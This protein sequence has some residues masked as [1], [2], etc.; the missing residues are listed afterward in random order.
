MTKAPHEF[1]RMVVR[2]PQSSGDFAAVGATAQ[3]A[4]LLGLHLMAAFIEDI[5][6][7]EVAGLPCVRE[8]RPLGGGW[9]PI[10]IGQLARELENAA[11]AARRDFEHLARSCR[12][13]TS[14][15]FARGS[16]AEVIHSLT[17]AEDIIVVIEPRN[18]AERVTQQFIRLVEAA[19]QAAAAVM[20]VPHRVLRTAGPV[21]AIAA[22]R[23]DP[24]IRV[25][26]AIA[27]AANERLIVLGA[28]DADA[29]AAIRE[30]AEAVGVEI[31]PTPQPP[32]SASALAA[33]LARLNERLVVMTRGACADAVPPAIAAQRGIPVLVIESGKLIEVAAAGETA[34]R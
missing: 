33:R 10:D 14:F 22:T 27:A 19:F 23:A 20:I 7:S 11:E 8:L 30:Q 17:T 25:G 4:E 29:Q 12:C 3:L 31:M 1:K 15:S 26:L 13:E 5:S 32:F 24:S 6:L 34:S 21:V 9:R 18:P 28:L 16:I 2:L